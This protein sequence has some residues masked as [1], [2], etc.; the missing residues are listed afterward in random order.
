MGEREWRQKM[1]V[2]LPSA[3]SRAQKVYRLT[4]SEARIRSTA[5]E[6]STLGE[7][8]ANSSVVNAKASIANSPTPTTITVKLPV[9]CV[10]RHTTCQLRLFP[11]CAC[12]DRTAYAS[13]RAPARPMSSKSYFAHL[14]L[15]PGGTAL[16]FPGRRKPLWRGAQLLRLRAC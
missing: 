7:F 5:W 10:V 3:P 12:A 2:E 16:P 11:A 15:R 14:R 4:A 13:R 6:Y 9:C 8:L 1:R